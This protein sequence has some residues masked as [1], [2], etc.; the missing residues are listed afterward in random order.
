MTFIYQNDPS[1]SAS[2]PPEEG[3]QVLLRHTR[4]CNKGHRDLAGGQER[5]VKG[6]NRGQNET[7][8]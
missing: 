4:A 6:S 5:M 1:F 7:L 2:R 3:C 8:P